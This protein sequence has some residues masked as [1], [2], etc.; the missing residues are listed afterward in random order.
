MNPWQGSA[1]GEQFRDMSEPMMWLKRT[2]YTAV[3]KQDR[4]NEQ[5]KAFSNENANAKSEKSSPAK[6]REVL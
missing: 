6:S 5:P 1:P 4:S 2:N 3:D